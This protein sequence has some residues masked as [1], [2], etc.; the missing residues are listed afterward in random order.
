MPEGAWRAAYR[1]LHRGARLVAMFVAVVLLG[2]ALYEHI[3]AWRDRRVL[4]Q[5][6][7]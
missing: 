7:R 1:L 3:G 6:G 2:A 5:I 4:K